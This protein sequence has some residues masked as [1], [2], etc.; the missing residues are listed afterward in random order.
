[1][2]TSI[3]LLTTPRYREALALWA[4]FFGLLVI[5]NSFQLES[6]EED[7]RGI[8]LFCYIH[9]SKAIIVYYRLLR[10]LSLRFT[11]VFTSDSWSTPCVL[12]IYYEPLFSFLVYACWLGAHVTSKRNKTFKIKKKS[13]IRRL[14]IEAHS[15]N[16]RCTNQSHFPLQF[17]LRHTE[18]CL[19][20]SGCL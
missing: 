1:M 18:H 17:P 13:F 12:W 4:R 11:A 9:S 20:I 5:H 16:I 3:V 6:K 19:S 2:H 7:I 8:K 14:K 10:C 15:R